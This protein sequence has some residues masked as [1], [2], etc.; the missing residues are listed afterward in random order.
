M[1]MY[2]RIE[3]HETKLSV[4]VSAQQTDSELGRKERQS[5]VVSRSVYSGNYRTEHNDLTALRDNVAN[6]M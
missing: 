6:V 4:N 5:P 1:K 3:T 2:N